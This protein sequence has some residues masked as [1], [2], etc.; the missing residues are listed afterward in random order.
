MVITVIMSIALALSLAGTGW[1]APP[2]LIDKPQA[3]KAQIACPVQGGKINQ[4]L[5]ADYQGQRVY[6]CCAE[7]IP[8]FKK[9]PEAYLKKLRQQGVTPEETPGGK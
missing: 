6:F 7:C 9:N 2:P 3:G 4:D 1:T 5:Y 8:I